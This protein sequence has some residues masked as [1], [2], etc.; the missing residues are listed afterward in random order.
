MFGRYQKAIAALVAGG[1][2]WA[3]VVIA[4]TPTAI[5]S[6]EWLGLAVVIATAL[7]VYAVPNVPAPAKPPAPPAP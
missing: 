3:G 7:G 4:S 1:V 2:G 5:T 6:S